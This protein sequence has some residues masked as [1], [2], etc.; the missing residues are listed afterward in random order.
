MFMMF[1]RWANSQSVWLDHGFNIN[2]LPHQCRDG[3]D[4]PAEQR[5]QRIPMNAPMYPWNR[6]ADVFLKKCCFHQVLLRKRVHNDV[7][8]VQIYLVEA[9]SSPFVRLSELWRLRA[10]NGFVF[11]DKPMKINYCRTGSSLSRAEPR[12]FDR[13]KYLCMGSMLR[14]LWLVVFQCT[15]CICETFKGV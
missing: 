7:S 4:A 6:S 5:T 15:H 13:R 10:L 12:L 1:S 8:W 9:Y 3:L 11:L 2:G 14:A